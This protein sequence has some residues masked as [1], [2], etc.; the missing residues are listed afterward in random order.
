MK[1]KYTYR[2]RVLHV[3]FLLA[4]LSL[5]YIFI[6]AT[7]M[8]LI[9]EGRPVETKWFYSYQRY[10]SFSLLYLPSFSLVCMWCAVVF[11]H[12]LNKRPN[13]INYILSFGILIGVVSFSLLFFCVLFL[14]LST[15]I[16]FEMY[17]FTFYL[18][19]TFL[20]WWVLRESLFILRS[21]MPN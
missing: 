8:G 11:G 17:W 12:F 20:C 10:Y 14:L 21:I 3:I 6:I 19:C 5:F 18:I 4:P 16:L 9:F 2:K 1:D 13:F 7:L 15:Y